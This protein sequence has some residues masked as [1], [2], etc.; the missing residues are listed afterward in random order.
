MPARVA[1][2]LEGNFGDAEKNVTVEMCDYWESDG[3]DH[4]LPAGM[5]D[6][7]GGTRI[8]F[9]NN[10]ALQEKIDALYVNNRRVKLP[11]THILLKPVIFRVKFAESKTKT[12]IE[13][14]NAAQQFRITPNP[15][16]SF[17]TVQTST[18]I[19]ATYQILNTQGDI[20]QAGILTTSQQIVAVQNLP[21]GF[22]FLR[23]C[24]ENREIVKTFVK[25]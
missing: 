18:M 12:A 7:A 14:L 6:L 19:P 22:Y 8:T 13:Q 1:Y 20:L 10:T 15:V 25:E 11:Y 16:R 21:Q 3:E 17:L 4:N 9:K 5:H 23:L 24:Y 2:Q